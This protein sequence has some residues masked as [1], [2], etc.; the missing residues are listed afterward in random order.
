MVAVLL[1]AVQ[2]IDQELII[3][4]IAPLLTR[5]H[6]DAG[7]HEIKQYAVPLTSDGTRSDGSD[8]LFYARS[9]DPARGTLRGLHI[10][11]R[12]P[13]GRAVRHYS[14][15]TAK[16]AGNGWRLASPLVESLILGV[17]GEAGRAPKQ[18][19]GTESSP[20]ELLIQTD[21]GPDAL[22]VRHFASFKQSLSLSQLT[23][24]LH[25]PALQPEQRA[26]LQ[27]IRYGRVSMLLSAFL[28]LIVSMPFFLMREPKNMVLQSLK[29]A[30]VGIVSLLGGVLGAATPIS[31]VPPGLAVFLPVAILVPVAIAAM[32]SMKT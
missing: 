16:W 27:R 26:G 19:S 2:V 23:S 9:F 8:R 28:S 15:E 3:P 14:A 30:P 21:L 13:N 6:G 12:D 29:S 24:M 20:G 18:A 11:D 4:R 32:M 1:A 10:W 7:R 22:N 5:D 25:N 17:P 31:G